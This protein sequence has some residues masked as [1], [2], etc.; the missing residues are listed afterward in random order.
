MFNVCTKILLF[1]LLDVFLLKS[2][3]TSSEWSHKK[4]MPIPF[5]FF[6]GGDEIYFFDKMKSMNFLLI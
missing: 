1:L 2:V 5:L 6:R 3:L 4:R